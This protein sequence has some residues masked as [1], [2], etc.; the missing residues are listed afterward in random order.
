MP[1]MGGLVVKI[2]DWQEWLGESRVEHDC[3]VVL[4]WENSHCFVY[5]TGAV[6]G[7]TGQVTGDQ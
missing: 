7:D 2:V 4:G 5:T 3:L 6:P 1:V